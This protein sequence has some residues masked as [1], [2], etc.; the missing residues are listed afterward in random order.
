[1][2]GSCAVGPD[3][4]TSKGS[5][6]TSESIK[7]RTLEGYAVFAKSPPFTLDTCFRI[8]FISKIAAPDFSNILF[9]SFKSSKEQPSGTSVKRADP[10]PEIKQISKSF[11]FAFFAIDII[12]S[13]PLIPFSSGTGCPASVIPI[14]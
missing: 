13:V 2:L 5:P 1:M 9:R 14:N 12:I 3:A 10:P 6:I 4:I 11:F 7:L 8:Q